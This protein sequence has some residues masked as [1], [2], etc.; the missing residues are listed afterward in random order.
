MKMKMGNVTL[1]PKFKPLYTS[2]ARYFSITGGRGSAKSFHVSD[3][4]LKLTYERGHVI[5]FSRYTMVSA[6]LS[7]IPEFRDKIETY[8]IEKAFTITKSEI[9]NNYTGSKILFKG[10]RTS[11]GNQTAALKSI[12]GVTTF[13]LDEAEELIDEEIFDKIDESIRKKGMRNRV[14][15]VLNPATKEHWIYKRFFE[16]AG[17]QE[18]SNKTVGDTTYIHTTYLDNLKNLSESF[19][20]KFD[21]LK[22][23]NPKKYAHRV[24]GGWLTKLDGVVYEN[25]K[26]GEFVNTGQVLFGQDYGYSPDPTTL[27]KVS[28]DQRRKQIYVDECFVEENLSTEQII[29]KNK[30]FCGRELIIGDSAEPRLINDIRNGGVNIRPCIKGAG[31]IMAGINAIKEYELIVSPNSTNIVKELNNYTYSDKK[32]QLVVDDYNHCF[33]GET[34]IKTS[35]GLKR[36]DQIKVGDL[37]LTSNGYN[38]VLKRFNNGYK[39]TYRYWMQFGTFSLYLDSTKTHR[40]KT[41]EGWKEIN[42]LKEGDKIFLY[43]NLMERHITFT[44]GK[45]IFLKEQKDCIGLF[46]NITKVKYQKVIMFIISTETLRIITLKTLVLLKKLCIYV[47]KAKNFIERIKN[48]VKNGIKKVLKQRKNGINQKKEENGTKNTQ[49]KHGLIENIELLYVRFAEKNIKQDTG[50]FQNTAMQIAK[51]KRCELGERKVYDLHVENK[52][53]YFANGI[54][55]HNCLDAIRYAVY[56]HLKQPKRTMRRT[57]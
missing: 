46:G 29:Q 39:K 44:K 38:K 27:I 40:V 55:V 14:I 28:I 10:I 31:S 50:E 15:F 37:V 9:V 22:I 54:L 17:V 8:G 26:I 49:K 11:S 52:H 23:K 6:H 57:N 41:L 19:I 43:K 21:A 4:L 32:S 7:I 25:W 24:L 47:L 35:K 42:Q 33:V 45:D 51:L 13:V 30:Q 53:E 36:I 56:G 20:E 5:L 34:L 2:D 18:G 1:I 16:E 3:F 12:Q 48:G